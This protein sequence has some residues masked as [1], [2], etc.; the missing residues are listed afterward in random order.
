MQVVDSIPQLRAARYVL[1][2]SVGLVPTMG[3]LHEGHLALVEAAK[4]ETKSVITTIFVNP[5]QFGPHED[6]AKYPRNLSRD[7]DLLKA[8]GVD[9]VF[10]PTSDLMYPD[11]FQ[12]WVEVTEVSQWLEGEQ[13]PGHFRGVATVVAKLFNLT[14]P[15]R[16]YFGQ[17]D[18][19]QVAVVKNMVRD[20]N[21][22]LDIVVCP[23]IREPDGLA[24]SSR[25]VYLTAEHRL[26]AA[27]V[28]KALQ[29]ANNA[30]YAGE[31]IPN[32]LR[33]SIVHTI[34]AEPLASIEYVSVADA[35][36]LQEIEQLA[37]KPILLSVAVKIGNVRLIDN[38]VLPEPKS[39]QELTQLLG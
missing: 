32:H 13:R 22:P 20:L 25:N 8:S 35:R 33:A 14:Q 18:A 27:I 37:E 23:T 15:D 36:T 4:S 39:R 10:T 21:F 19:Q 9:L 28:Y 12:T 26:A 3:A 5:T 29:S 6:L 2:D 34:Q 11:G 30:Y 31:R 17:K 1:G 16:A 38:F 24:K 7:L